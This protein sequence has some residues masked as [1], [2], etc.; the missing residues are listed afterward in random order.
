M[1]VV[2]G[3]VLEGLGAGAH[4]AHDLLAHARGVRGAVAHVLLERGGALEA[5]VVADFAEGGGAHP[6]SQS[7]GREGRGILGREEG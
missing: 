3:G 2:R 7:E 6:R 1:I 5:L 4:G